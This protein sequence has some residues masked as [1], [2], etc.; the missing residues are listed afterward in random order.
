VILQPAKISW[1]GPPGPMPHTFWDTG[2][3]AWIV[4]QDGILRAGCQPALVGLF[5]SDSGGLP[6]RRTQRVLLPTCPTVL[7]AYQ[8]LGKVCGIAPL[9]RGRP[10]RSARSEAGRAGPGGPA[11]TR[12]SSLRW[13]AAMLRCSQ[14]TQTTQNDRLRHQTSCDKLGV[15]HLKLR[16][17]ERLIA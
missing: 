17:M 12:A 7:A 6:T 10:P 2:H 1:D 15:P 14:T 13:V 16:R 11:R 4:G 3:H 9:A 8:V 5:T